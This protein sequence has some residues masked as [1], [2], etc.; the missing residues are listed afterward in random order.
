MAPTA[1]RD[2]AD[3]PLPYRSANRAEVQSRR[4]QGSQPHNPLLNPAVD[5]DASNPAVNLDANNPAPKAVDEAEIETE[6]GTGRVIVLKATKNKTS[7]GTRN[8]YV[9][10]GHYDGAKSSFPSTLATKVRQKAEKPDV[11]RHFTLQG[12]ESGLAADYTKRSHCIRVRAEGEQFLI[13]AADDRGVIDWIE[14]V[15]F[16]YHGLVAFF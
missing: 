16:V 1:K 15:G 11:I 7:S 5:L 10:E 13:Q 2:Q 8:I 6:S 14:A 9:H 4:R 3:P 12:A